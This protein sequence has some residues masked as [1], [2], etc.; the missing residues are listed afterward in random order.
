MLE[1]VEEILESEVKDMRKMHDVLTQTKV[2]QP[3]NSENPMCAPKGQ[4]VVQLVL[5]THPLPAPNHYCMAPRCLSQRLFF[6][7]H[8]PPLMTKSD[9]TSQHIKRLYPYTQGTVPLP[10]KLI[11]N[12]F[13]LS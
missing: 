10:L 3:F 13:S 7:S 5:A 4:I 6:P 8:T 9:P 11:N 12:L 1:R 2:P